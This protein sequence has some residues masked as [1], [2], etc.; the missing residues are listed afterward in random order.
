MWFFITDN[1]KS[2]WIGLLPL[3]PGFFI[4]MILK[5]MP[6]AELE[7]R[8]IEYFGKWFGVYFQVRSMCG[9][10]R[11]D[12]LLY[13]QSDIYK[14]YPIGLE[15]KK[16]DIKRGTDIGKWCLQAQSYTKAMFDEKTPFVFTA[17]Q[18][19]GWYISEGKLVSQH[20]IDEPGSFSQQNNVNSFLY[21]SFSIGEMQKYYTTWPKRK[22]QFRLVMNT[23]LIWSS[24]KPSFLN[25]TNLERL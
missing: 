9:K 7:S 19:T 4:I 1:N 2:R 22:D 20:P 3:K 15:V 25:V 17:P 10:Y 12:L 5:E 11:I 23:Y 14:C 21:K 16:G 6:E 13:H 8:L 24:E 18:I